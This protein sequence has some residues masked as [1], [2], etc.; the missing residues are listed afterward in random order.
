MWRTLTVL[1]LFFWMVMATL[2][3]RL[4]YFPEGS[5]F[6]KVP[7]EH[8]LKMFLEQGTI[9]NTLHIYHHDKK[10]GSATLDTRKMA[11]GEGSGKGDVI[12]A[13]GLIDKGAFPQMPGQMVWRLEMLLEDMKRLAGSSGYIRLTENAMNLE[14]NWEPGQRL[15]RFTLKQKGQLVADDQMVEPMIHQMMG[16]GN[17]GAFLPEGVKLPAQGDASSLIEVKSREGAM[18]FAGHK[19]RGYVIEFSFMEHYNAKV[20]FTEAGELALVDLPDGYRLVEPVIHNLEP[21]YSE[22]EEPAE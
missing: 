15:P 4:V 10:L 3:V 22:E 6:A 1:I 20:F 17:S 21:D 12:I 9:L 11:P 7:P 19:T 16:V 2:L 8:V 14:F 5:Q 18:T 13:T